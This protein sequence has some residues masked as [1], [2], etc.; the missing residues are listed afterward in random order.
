MQLTNILLAYTNPQFL[1]DQILPTVPDL[2]EESGKIGS[3]GNA[4]LRQYST[5]RSLYD[6]SEHRIE[7]TISNDNSY[8][9][10]YFDLDAYVPDRLQD[11]LQAPFNALNAAQM[12]VMEA[13][14]LEREIALAA[15][16]TS[17][18]IITN[19]TTL[20]G[21]SKYTDG[22]NSTPES[23]FD[24]ARDS[25]QTKTG[26]EANAVYMSRK[27]MNALRRHPWFL[28]IAKSSLAG[29]AAKSGALSVNA[30]IETLKAWYDLQY[31]FIGSQIKITSAEGQTETKGAVWGDDVVW[32]YRTPAPSLFAPSFGY[33]FQLAGNNLQTR[34][35][36]HVNDKGDI[37][38][39][40][41]AYQDKI[42]DTNCAYLIKNAV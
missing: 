14:K 42:L 24:T 15:A 37:V 12:T 3:M 16:L 31:V 4:H 26:R 6:E 20:S 1:A 11:Q 27:V 30:F 38:E 18:S 25:V 40:I 34:V 13:M 8:Q 17:T 32:F 28:D 29:G 9:I 22:A 19:N 35:R 23:D 36:R 5:K 41:W 10:D 2:K 7:F 39:V 33:S 21:S